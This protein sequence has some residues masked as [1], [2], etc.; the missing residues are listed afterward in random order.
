MSG[1][2]GIPRR[3]LRR[4]LRR[5][6]LLLAAHYPHDAYAFERCDALGVIVQSGNP[7]GQY[8][9][10]MPPMHTLDSIEQNYADSKLLPTIRPRILGLSNELNGSHWS[11]AAVP[12]G[13]FSAERRSH[14]TIAFYALW[15]RNWTPPAMWA[16]PPMGPD[17]SKPGDWQA[18]FIAVNEYKGWWRRRLLKSSG[19]D[20]YYRAGTQV[21]GG[22]RWCGAGNNFIRM[23]T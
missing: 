16:L 7:V 4:T 19:G 5:W 21:P 23:T 15:R 18:D 6:D 3:R 9:G 10:P 22:R 8:W 17:G 13:G 2:G 11:S 20:G 1:D 14:G 12:Q